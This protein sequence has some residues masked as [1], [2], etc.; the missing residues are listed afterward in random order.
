MRTI[1]A[2]FP[3]IL[4]LALF[5][6]TSLAD[7]PESTTQPNCA[8][9][10]PAI[11]VS[12]SELTEK[13]NFI[14]RKLSILGATTMDELHSQTNETADSLYKQAM[15]SYHEHDY[16]K[17]YF[18]AKEL[19]VHHPDNEHQVASFVVAGRS[20]LSIYNQSR[21]T[22]KASFWYTAEPESH[23]AQVCSMT[24][25]N[26]DDR[27]LIAESTLLNSPLHY[28]KRFDRFVSTYYP[29]SQWAKIHIGEDNGRV[30][31]LF[32]SESE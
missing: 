13:L 11:E 4:P 32:F 27:Q 24:P 1:K 7:S 9:D 10:S 8:G 21:H 3:H 12:I 5:S 23:F 20:L 22:N 2:T 26:T 16:P 6:I 19:L 25:K 29:Q 14:E 17:A 15:N 18:F 31:R 30:D 28:W